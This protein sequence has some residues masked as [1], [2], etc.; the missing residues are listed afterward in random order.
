MWTILSV[1]SFALLGCLALV[2]WC[3]RRTLAKY[4]SEAVGFVHT[5]AVA[6]GGGERV[7]WLAIAGLMRDDLVHKRKRRYV[8]YCTIP[9]KNRALSKNEITQFV[10]EKVEK[11]FGISLLGKLDVVPLRASVVS[12]SERQYPIA[13]LFFQ[14]FF[15]GFLLFYECAIA[16]IMTPVVFDTLGAPLLY[17]LLRVWSG[18]T[19]IAY[20]HF[21]IASPE[22][23]N[24]IRHG[25]V[26]VSNATLYTSHFYLQ[27]LKVIYYYLFMQFYR[28]LGQ[29][30]HL[31]FTN[32]TWTDGH[33]RSIFCPR[34]SIILYPPCPVRE[35]VS[36]QEKED[37]INLRANRVVSI[38]QF[39]PAKNHPLQIEAF[40]AAL[41][42]LPEDA[43][44]ILI[45]GAR[46]ANDYNLV[47][48]LKSL[49]RKLN[50]ENKVEFRVNE[51]YQELHRQLRMGLIGLHAMRNENFGIAI[52]EYMGA[53]CV[54]LAHR[55]GG[56][57]LDIVTSSELGYL[58]ESKEEYTKALIEI[59][60]Q[61][62]VA[63]EEIK[64]MRAKGLKH[65]QQFDD[66]HFQEKFTG[67]FNKLMAEQ[68]GESIWI[69]QKK[70]DY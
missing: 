62:N 29:Y 42:E 25:I 70:R 3:R 50:I 47:Q 24:E 2:A 18:C 54:V 14:I 68:K 40:A 26:S 56:V 45:G 48:Q 27:W 64:K 37:E 22:Q 38:G 28:F 53:G 39:R 30:P 60:H 6:C 41:P 67:Y 4:P 58:A 59:F 66:L 16:N 23:I 51:S 33:I 32:S 11:K 69:G 49:V 1:F 17:L 57:R 55:S 7:L 52:V 31:V 12:W 8:V 46:T 44:L 61:N 63:P 36:R 20:I 9:E 10:Q 21:P 19:T 5:A 13:T 34:K 15:G 35:L 43:K 65:V